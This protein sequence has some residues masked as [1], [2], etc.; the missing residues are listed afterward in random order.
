MG[1]FSLLLNSF[2]FCHFA[3]Y[4]QE[5]T[6]CFCWVSLFAAFPFW[7]S[8]NPFCHF[9]FHSCSFENIS[10]LNLSMFLGVL[11]SPYFFYNRLVSCTVL[12][13]TSQ[14]WSDIFHMC[15]T[16]ISWDQWRSQYTGFRG[17]EPHEIFLKYYINIYIYIYGQS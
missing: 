10:H 9:W 13:S 12:F 15:S 2:I 17:L 14:K 11:G 8:I 4:F 3:H 16:A 1:S 5:T 7:T 6:N